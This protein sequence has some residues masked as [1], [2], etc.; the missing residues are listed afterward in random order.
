MEE[1]L[2]QT[3]ARLA[4]LEKRIEHIEDFLI[5]GSEDWDDPIKVLESTLID[6]IRSIINKDFYISVNVDADLKGN[7][8]D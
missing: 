4:D 2:F 8:K 3:E 7:Y 1:L 5:T 6:E